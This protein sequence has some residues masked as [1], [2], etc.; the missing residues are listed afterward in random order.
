MAAETSILSLG[1]GCGE[2][3]PQARFDA[4]GIVLPTA[5]KALGAYKPFLTVG[6]HA[7]VS[8]HLPIL[9]DGGMLK[10]RI[11][12]DLDA[13]GGK[14][15]ARQAGLAIL[16]TLIAHTGSLDRIA[17]VVKVLGLVCSSP[18]FDRH[19]HVVNGCSELF[20]AVWGQEVGVGV[21]S[22]VGVASLPAGAAVE[23]EAQFE[24]A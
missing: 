18:D 11:G 1:P 8:G 21:R 17:R 5:P 2:S 19:P 24:L 3:A 13:D 10:G 7:Y 16:A 15:A 9:A 23:I 22:A 14:Q 20:A 6:R 12:D 4:L